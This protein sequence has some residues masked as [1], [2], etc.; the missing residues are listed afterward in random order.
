LARTS[1]TVALVFDV[2]L[3]LLGEEAEEADG[4]FA[5]ISILFFYNL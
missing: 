3:S 2:P 4:V 1:G 5:G